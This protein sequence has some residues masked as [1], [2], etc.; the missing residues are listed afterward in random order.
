MRIFADLPIKADV[1]TSNGR[2][3][4]KDVLINTVKHFNERTQPLP[5]CIDTP[6]TVTIDAMNELMIGIADSVVL[7]QDGTLQ[8]LLELNPKCSIFTKRP[9]LY[10]EIKKCYQDGE[11]EARVT[12]SVN[13]YNEE[14][15]IVD[16]VK[17][18]LV[19][20]TRKGAV[21]FI[22]MEEIKCN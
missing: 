3:Y 2:L 19:F 5:L 16:G 9:T 7:L 21:P 13:D 8:A 14:T 17:I 22:N 12:L 6:P 1:R 18:L 10:D 15:G 11:L 20:F 4:T